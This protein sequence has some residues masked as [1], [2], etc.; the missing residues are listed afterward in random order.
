MHAALKSRTDE[1]AYLLKRA[2]EPALACTRRDRVILKGGWYGGGSTPPT[3]PAPARYICPSPFPR[4]GLL[5]FG[6]GRG[7]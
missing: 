2:G 4:L 7:G 6:G 3:L 1:F 5:T